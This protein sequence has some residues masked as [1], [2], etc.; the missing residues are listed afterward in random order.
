MVSNLLQIFPKSIVPP[1]S[2]L[3][4]LTLKSLATHM[5][6]LPD[7]PEEKELKWLKY[8]TTDNDLQAQRLQT[9]KD[10][11]YLAKPESPVM[12]STWNYVII[13]AAIEQVA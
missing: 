13:G 6:G 7:S 10:A 9:V 8:A 5:S 1:E 11:A 12:H 3:A 4:D 2:P